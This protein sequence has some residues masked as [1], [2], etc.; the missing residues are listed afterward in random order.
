MRFLLR[1]LRIKNKY[2]SSQN[3]IFVKL[4][5]GCV[6]VLYKSMVISS[7]GFNSRL[8]GLSLAPKFERHRFIIS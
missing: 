5:N 2:L 7:G 6:F 1:F 4:L 3:I 8:R